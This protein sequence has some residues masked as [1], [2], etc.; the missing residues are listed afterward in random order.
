M[1]H[2]EFTI[3]GLRKRALENGLVESYVMN[4]HGSAGQSISLYFRYSEEKKEYTQKISTKHEYLPIAIHPSMA[5]PAA[6]GADEVVS[7]HAFH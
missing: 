6:R 7:P 4:Q 2:S 3:D 5:S 1:E